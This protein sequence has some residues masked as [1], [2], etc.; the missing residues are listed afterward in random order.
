MMKNVEKSS[1]GTTTLTII[2]SIEQ[3]SCVNVSMFAIPQVK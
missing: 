3:P 2:E 1:D